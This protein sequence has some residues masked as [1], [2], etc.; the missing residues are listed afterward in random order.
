MSYDPTQPRQSDGKFDSKQG[1]PAT[2]S[3]VNAMRQ[4]PTSPRWRQTKA[5]EWVVF[6]PVDA[7]S[8]KAEVAVTK[9][10]GETQTVRLRGSGKPFDVG[11]VACCYGYVD[12]HAKASTGAR[13]S[14]GNGHGQ[15]SRR[16]GGY[17]PCDECGEGRGT[18]RRRDSSGI[19][20]YVCQ[21]CNYSPSYELSF[22]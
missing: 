22:A 10:N 11:G 4:A 12:Q 3:A 17:Q 18:Y 7:I 8:G 19:E 6:G 20:G 16:R 9:A 15:S 5:G 1:L 2:E 13:Q 21:R 14:S